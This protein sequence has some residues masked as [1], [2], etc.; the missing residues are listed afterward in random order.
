MS[1]TLK[2]IRATKIV[3]MKTPLDTLPTKSFL[4]MLIGECEMIGKNACRDVTE[5]EVQ[6]H[7]RKVLKGIIETMDYTPAN[8]LWMLHIERQFIEALLPQMASEDDMKAIIVPLANE[9]KPIGQI[10]G[11]VKKSFGANADMKLAAQIVKEL[12]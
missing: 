11:A 1:D 4:A 10:M 3:Q 5:D 12:T 2:K 6:K 7:L 9:G 8:E